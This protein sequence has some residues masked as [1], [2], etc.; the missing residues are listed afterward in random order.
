MQLW[1]N[2]KTKLYFSS[3]KFLISWIQ[4]CPE[5]DAFYYKKSDYYNYLPVWVMNAT[6]WQIKPYRNE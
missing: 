6:I 2:I 3:F 5:L 4:E 1:L